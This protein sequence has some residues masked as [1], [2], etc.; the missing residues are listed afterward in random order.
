MANC[1]YNETENTKNLEIKNSQ[2]KPTT[3]NFKLFYTKE[4]KKF[5]KNIVKERFCFSSGIY[6]FGP[7]IQDFCLILQMLTS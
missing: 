5:L 7:N 1:L 2:V 3:K 6:N 4:T